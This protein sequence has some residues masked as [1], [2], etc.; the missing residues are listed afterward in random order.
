MS[1]LD[2]KVTR[3][4][5]PGDSVLAVHFLNGTVTKIEQISEGTDKGDLHISVGGE[6]VRMSGHVLETQGIG[7]GVPIK[8]FLIEYS[9]RDDGCNMFYFN[10]FHPK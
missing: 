2:W 9:I 6:E 7:I 1:K 4:L 10:D 3:R 5:Q 8:G